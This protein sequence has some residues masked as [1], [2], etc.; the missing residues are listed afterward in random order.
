MLLKLPF[1]S[2]VG[3]GYQARGVVRQPGKQPEVLRVLDMRRPSESPIV[4][5]ESKKQKKEKKEE[6]QRKHKRKKSSHKDEKSKKHRKEKVD[7]DAHDGGAFVDFNPLL[8]YFASNI[9]N[10]TRVFTLENE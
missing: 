8:Q 3:Q 7:G 6:H 2:K 5:T 4:E 9:S 1:L 10:K